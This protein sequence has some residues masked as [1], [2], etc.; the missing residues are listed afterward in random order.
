MSNANLRI[1]NRQQN[2]TLSNL[3]MRFKVS[4]TLSRSL[5]LCIDISE[6]YTDGAEGG[7]TETH[8]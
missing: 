6:E 5:I 1:F 4:V 2:F 7:E 3:W 8:R